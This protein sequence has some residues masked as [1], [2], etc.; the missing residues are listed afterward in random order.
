MINDI[1]SGIPWGLFLSFMIGPVFFILLETSIIKGFRAALVFD[2]GVVLGDVFAVAYLGSYRLI[3]SLQDK[4]A[5]FIFGGILMLM[6]LSPFEF[7]KRKEDK[8]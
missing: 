4:P 1:L 5:L 7:T 6:V 3:Q 2:L 8:N